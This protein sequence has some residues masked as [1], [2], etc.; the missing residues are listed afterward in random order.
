[1]AK[2]TNPTYVP[3][4]V[5]AM[6]EGNER[7]RIVGVVHASGPEAAQLRAA[8]NPAIRTRAAGGYLTV[9]PLSSRQ[10][11][12]VEELIERREALEAELEEVTGKLAAV[13]RMVQSHR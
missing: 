11:E 8:A 6:S 4:L 13:K 10:A 5:F 2:V 1:M 12:L 9:K 7:S 3:F